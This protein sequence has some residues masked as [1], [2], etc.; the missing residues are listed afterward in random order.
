MVGPALPSMAVVLSAAAAND[1]IPLSSPR[2]HQKQ[3]PAP[4]RSL[5]QSSRLR[6]Q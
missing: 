1:N 3:S 5:G 2:T 4:L 6:D